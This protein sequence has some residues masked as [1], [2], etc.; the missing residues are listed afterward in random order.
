MTARRRLR[1]AAA[2]LAVAAALAACGGATTTSTFPPLGYTPA[3]V[4]DATDATVQQVIAAVASSGLQAGVSDRPYRPPEGPLLAAAPRTVVQV[5]LPDDPDHGF[6]VIYA[7]GSPAAAVAAASDTAAYLAR[8]PGGILPVTGTHLV[9]RVVGS[10]V[11]Y[12]KWSPDN[13]PDARTHLIEDSLSTLGT[14]TQI[15]G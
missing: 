11:I 2:G 15:S 10:T 7:L 6:I 3:P 5:Q 1:V 8:N 4:G 12:F 14:G 13:A 9:L